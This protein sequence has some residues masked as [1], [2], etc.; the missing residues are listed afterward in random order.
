[1]RLIVEK[2]DGTRYLDVVVTDQEWEKVR[3]KGICT[4]FTGTSL[5]DQYFN[6]FIRK[7][8]T[9]KFYAIEEGPIK[10]SGQRERVRI[11][12]KWQISETGCCDQSEESW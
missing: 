7:E 4:E 6:I 1:M 12:K 8:G 3:C 2:I 5:E 11:G 10:Q 9:E